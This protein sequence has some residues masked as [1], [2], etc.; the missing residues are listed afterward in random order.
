M[1]L[2]ALE[3]LLRSILDCNSMSCTRPPKQRAAFPGF[4]PV[5]SRCDR[6]SAFFAAI[7]PVRKLV[8]CVQPMRII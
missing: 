2:H 3:R 5:E 1:Q 4:R 7:T 6:G 8:R